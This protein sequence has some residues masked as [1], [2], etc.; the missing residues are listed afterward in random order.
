[1][2]TPKERS[3]IYFIGDK[4]SKCNIDPQVAFVGTRSYKT[5]LEW[6]HRMNLSINNICLFNV[7]EFVKRVN[8][9]ETL[10]I[11]EHDQIVAL[12]RVASEALDKAILPHLRIPHPSGLNRKLNDPR[13]VNRFLKECK[14]Y[15]LQK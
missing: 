7:E 5:L 12:G 14:D 3:V 4:P 2:V 13:E 15:V 1:M 9:D 8:K 6:I 11:H 10:V